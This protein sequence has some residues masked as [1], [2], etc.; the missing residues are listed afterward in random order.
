MV[1]VYVLVRRILGP[2][3]MCSQLQYRSRPALPKNSLDTPETASGEN[4][5]FGLLYIRVS[6]IH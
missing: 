3:R 4:G 5:H 2:S 1:V 6:I